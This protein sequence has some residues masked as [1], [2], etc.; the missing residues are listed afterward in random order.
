M[1]GPEPLH[2]EH[3][4]SPRPL[5]VSAIDDHPL[6]LRG[7][8]AHLAELA[9][10]IDLVHVAGSVDG[11]LSTWPEPSDVVLLDLNLGDTTDPAENV[12]RLRAAGTQV[13][14]F[15]SEHRPAL[16]SRALGAGAVGLVL[17]EDPP[18]RVV[19][20]I[21]AAAAGRFSVSSRMAFQVVN[22]PAGRIRL[23]DRERDV[24]GLLARGL[25]WETAARLLGISTETARTHVR[26]AMEKYADE[27]AAL[28]NG[29]KELVFR[30]VV[31]G[32]VDPTAG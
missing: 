14:L 28:L 22:D 24:L 30:A 23:S 31:D 20:A 13:V 2:G 3:P 1:T 9:P 4:A 15:T 27:G 7:L 18:D 5:T 29:P 12:A 32:H 19:E 16:V 21:V 25:P 11:L 26:R 17:K 8:G 6:M 10:R